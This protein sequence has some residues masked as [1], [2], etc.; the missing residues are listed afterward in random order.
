MSENDLTH[1]NDLS[2]ERESVVVIVKGREKTEQPSS[3]GI[4]LEKV[5][6]SR[7]KLKKQKLRKKPQSNFLQILEIFFKEFKIFIELVKTKILESK[8]EVYTNRYS[9]R[10]LELIHF[11]IHEKQ[12]LE[13]IKN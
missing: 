11:V 6:T 7:K 8:N 13:A 4:M 3:E 2:S 5:E 9:K 12:Y 1:D 10:T